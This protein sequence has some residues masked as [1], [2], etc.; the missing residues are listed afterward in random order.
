MEEDLK[1]Q[2]AL[3]EQI[4]ELQKQLLAAKGM[5]YPVY[6]PYI[7]YAPIDPWQPWKPWPDYPPIWTVTG[8]TVP[9]ELSESAVTTGS[10]AFVDDYTLTNTKQ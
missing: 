1:K 3:L 6:V 7:P 10:S 4:I 8:A 9:A 2:I 5:S